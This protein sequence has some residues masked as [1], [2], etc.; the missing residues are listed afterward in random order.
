[1]DKETCNSVEVKEK[2]R[3]SRSRVKKPG[4][5][6][7]REGYKPRDQFWSWQ[8]G[9]YLLYSS[10]KSIIPLGEG[11]I[12]VDLRYL[13]S[14]LGIRVDRLRGH[15]EE[16]KRIGVIEQIIYQKYSVVLMLA[17]P[18]NLTLDRLEK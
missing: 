3:V 5:L 12:T 6:P 9:I 11:R 16:L 1:M 10:I 7:A 18:R 4:G 13:A 8:V 15:L 14:D 2:H 17:P